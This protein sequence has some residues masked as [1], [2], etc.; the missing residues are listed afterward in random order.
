MNTV[1]KIVLFGL[2]AIVVSLISGLIISKTIS[3]SIVIQGASVLLTILIAAFA[4][5]QYFSE[6][7]GENLSKDSRDRDLNRASPHLQAAENTTDC[8]QNRDVGDECIEEDDNAPSEFNKH[9]LMELD[10]EI[11]SKEAE[12]PDGF[13]RIYEDGEIRI[14]RK[15]DLNIYTVMMTY[16]IAARYAFEEGSRESPVVSGAELSRELGCKRAEI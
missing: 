14:D 15:N 9:G 1:I 10:S 13:F 7:D 5:L 8:S 6:R 4:A 16:V 2:I 12:R 3:D 11:L